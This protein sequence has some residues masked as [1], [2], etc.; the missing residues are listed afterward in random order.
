MLNNSFANAVVG[1]LLISCDSSLISTMAKYLQFYY[2]SNADIDLVLFTSNCA[3][4]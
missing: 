4:N 3:S 2:Y 1:S